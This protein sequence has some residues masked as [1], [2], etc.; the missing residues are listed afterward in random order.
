MRLGSN[1][2]ERYT[3]TAQTGATAQERRTGENMLTQVNQYLSFI[4]SVLQDIHKNW[5]SFVC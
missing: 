1:P 4:A 5:S 3:Q 2:F